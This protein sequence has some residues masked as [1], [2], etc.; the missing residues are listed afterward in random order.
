MALTRS[1]KKI[2]AFGLFM[3]VLAVVA[4]VLLAV[5][6]TECLS[7]KKTQEGSFFQTIRFLGKRT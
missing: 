4:L 6:T 2:D 1:E 7:K 5:F 3:I